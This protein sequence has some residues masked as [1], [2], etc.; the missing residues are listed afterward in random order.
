MKLR[1]KVLQWQI[2]YGVVSFGTR[3]LPWVVDY[4]R[5]QREHH[6]A[7]SVYDRLERISELGEEPDKSG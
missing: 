5:N 7:G 2:G 6:A 3:E 1:G 4:I